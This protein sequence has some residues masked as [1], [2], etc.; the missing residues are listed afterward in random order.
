MEE[1]QATA[2]PLAEEAGFDEVP[3]NHSYKPDY[4]PDEDYQW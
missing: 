4:D 2:E 1:A 3:N